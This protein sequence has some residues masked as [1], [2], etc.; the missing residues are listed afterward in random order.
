[1]KAG[2]IGKSLGHTASP[3]IHEKIYQ[4]MG[5]PER[6]M[7]WKCPRTSWKGI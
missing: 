4:A 6:M 3:A 5:Y 1:M 2:L 7:Y